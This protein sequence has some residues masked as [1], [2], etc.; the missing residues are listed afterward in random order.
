LYSPEYDELVNGTCEA[1]ANGKGNKDDE[2]A[3]DC[4]ATTDEI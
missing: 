3:N 1:T 4:P 2:R